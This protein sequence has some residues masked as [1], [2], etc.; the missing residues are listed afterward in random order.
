MKEKFNYGKALEKMLEGKAVSCE[1]WPNGIYVQL[2]KY[3]EADIMILTDIN[4]KTNV[5]FVPSVENQIIDNW[6]VVN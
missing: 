3:M 1:R 6:F 4:R 5:Q 2:K